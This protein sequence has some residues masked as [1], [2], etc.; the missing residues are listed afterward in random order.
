MI[1]SLKTILLND[2]LL[3]QKFLFSVWNSHIQIQFTLKIDI[4]PDT[5]TGS[6]HQFYMY[7]T[8]V[9]LVLKTVHVIIRISD[10]EILLTS[11]ISLRQSCF[12][13]NFRALEMVKGKFTKI[14]LSQLKSEMVRRLKLIS[15]FTKPVTN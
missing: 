12:F 1:F 15:C 14:F 9:W 3:E 7:L 8:T 5:N 2:I 6:F 11:V 4:P 13:Y 10:Q